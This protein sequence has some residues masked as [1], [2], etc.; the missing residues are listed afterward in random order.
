MKIFFGANDEGEDVALMVLDGEGLPEEETKVS[1]ALEG[2][3]PREELRTVMRPYPADGEQKGFWVGYSGP[4][5]SDERWY[6]INA[7]ADELGAQL[8]TM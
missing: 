4:W 6:H 1:N 7:V 2:L 8:Y 5:Q 3:L